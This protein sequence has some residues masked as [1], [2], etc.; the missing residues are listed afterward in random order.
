MNSGC[1]FSPVSWAHA[2]PCQRGDITACNLELIDE[3][4]THIL[5]AFRQANPQVPWR[6]VIVTHNRLIHGYRCIDN[7]TPWR[8][9]LR[10]VPALLPR[11]LTL[12]AQSE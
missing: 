7:D 12:K 11:L 4:A 2:I 1:W 3:A 10:D 9:F 6:L 5:D 8:I